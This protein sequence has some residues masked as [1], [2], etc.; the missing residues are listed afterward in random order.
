YMLHHSNIRKIFVA[1][2]TPQAFLAKLAGSHSRYEAILEAPCLL[3]PTRTAVVVPHSCSL[4]S[5]SLYGTNTVVFVMNID[6]F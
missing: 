1:I 3:F 5:R 4:F 2:N 6:Q